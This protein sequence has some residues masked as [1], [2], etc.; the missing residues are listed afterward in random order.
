MKCPASLSG[1]IPGRQ[2]LLDTNW[3]GSCLISLFISVLSGIVLAFQYDWTEP[4]YSTTTIEVVVPFGFF[5]RGLHYYSSQAFFL[6]LLVHLVIII[7][8]NEYSF[9][10]SAWIRLTMSIPV[11]LLLLF[12]GYVLRGDAT[13]EAAGVIAENITL[14]LPFIGE[15][16]NDL[17]FALKANGTK[18]VYANHL[19]S[20]MV[21]GGYCI[22]PHLRRYTSPWRNHL[23]VIISTLFLSILVTAPMEPDQIG[24]LHIQGPWFFLGLQELLRYM[25][26]FWAGIF[27]PSIVIIALFLMPQ[28]KEQKSSYIF[29]MLGWILIYGILSFISLSRV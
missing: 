7:W 1:G 6:F 11:A 22:W 5:W 3:G 13:G 25:H 24:L 12:T 10:Q 17:L 2:F 21:L 29:L 9:K 18:R 27:F 16:L 28:E 15:L 23:V 20:L 8:K 4:F 14:S 19:I 26:P